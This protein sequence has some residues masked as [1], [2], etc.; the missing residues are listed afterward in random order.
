[1]KRIQSPGQP[2]GMLELLAFMTSHAT[3]EVGAPGFTIQ[4]WIPGSTTPTVLSNPL[5]GDDGPERT[6]RRMAY[7][8]L[9]VTLPQSQKLVWLPLVKRG[10]TDITHLWSQRLTALD[11]QKV[12]VAAAIAADTAGPSKPRQE[13]GQSASL[14]AQLQGQEPQGHAHSLS[15]KSGK[16]VKRK[17]SSGAR[18]ADHSRRKR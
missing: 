13:A 5:S 12:A 4:L 16:A 14:K 9:L 11:Q 3:H 6:R 10:Y 2:L 7:N 1:M 18:G 8:L 15:A 17:L